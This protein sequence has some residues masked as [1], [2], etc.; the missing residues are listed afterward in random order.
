M[1]MN[2]SEPVE[3]PDLNGQPS[4]CSICGDRATGK[5]YGAASCDGCKG[6]FRRSVRKNHQYTCR[7]CRG[8]VV[9][10]DKRNQCRYCRLKKCFR[11]GMKKEACSST[12]AVQNER[13]R[14]STRRPSYEDSLQ[15][16]GVSIPQ[17]VNAEHMSRQVIPN[18]V[19]L[20]DGSIAGKKIATM[21]DVCESM[22][23]HLLVLV[24]W[25]KYIPSFC[26]LPLDDQVALLRAHAGEHLVLG[27]ARRSLPYKDI[28]VLGPD[29]ILPRHSQD[30]MDIHRVASR[31][32][33]ELIAPMRDVSLDDHEFA[34]LKAIVFFD[35]DAKGL[36]EPNRI[37]MLRYQVQIH[38]EDYINDRQYDS[39][40]RFGEILLMLPPLQ[41]IT[42]Q[43]IE[44]I[45]FARLMGVAKVDNL[46]QEMLLGG[47][48]NDPSQQHVPPSMPGMTAHPPPTPPG[49]QHSLNGHLM[50]AAA[51]GSV[52]HLSQSS[53]ATAQ[54]IADFKLQQ[55]SQAAVTVPQTHIVTHPPAT[56]TAGPPAP[57]AV[58][59]TVPIP[60]QE[61][62]QINA[63]LKEEVV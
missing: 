23:Q 32:L 35:P 48:A 29:V 15:N 50:H 28:L 9:D 26:D 55:A 34:C 43:M 47:S 37:K 11:A 25:A 49:D 57:A 39:R 18:P 27:A 40:G 46:L 3:E 12:P 7:F 19:N 2:K 20:P 13:D 62:N 6:F 60:K 61:R 58:A 30:Q 14:I 4:Q 17:L 59:V 16:G 45:Q 53:A 41:S 10:K 24:E 36:S 54:V 5:H 1:S 63:M 21:N 22:K 56:A 33:D 51:H 42:W 8:C 44:Q 31:V 52:P 38:L